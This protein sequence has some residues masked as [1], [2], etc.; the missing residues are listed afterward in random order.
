MDEDINEHSDENRTPNLRE[1]NE[2]PREF[3]FSTSELR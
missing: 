2:T 1:P 3:D